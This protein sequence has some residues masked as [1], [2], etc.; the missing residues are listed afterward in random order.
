MFGIDR[1]MLL[2]VVNTIKQAAERG[3]TVY[4]MGNGGSAATASHFANDLVKAC[5][6]RAVCISDLMSLVLAYGN[7]D[8][9]HTMFSHAL[10][11]YRKPGDVLLVFS[12]SG[13]SGNVLDA[14]KMWPED[15]D[16]IAFTGNDHKSKLCTGTDVTVLIFVDDPDIMVQESVHLALCHAIVGALKAKSLESILDA[17]PESIQKVKG[18]KL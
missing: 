12:C 11:V 14:V 8:G 10:K 17:T 3:S 4:L 15:D 9:W 18:K 7:D 16:V 5:G 2:V 13:Y 1:Q 6:V